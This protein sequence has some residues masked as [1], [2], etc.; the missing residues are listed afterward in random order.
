MSMKKVVALL[1]VFT[2]AAFL[3]TG[4]SSQTLGYRKYPNV[5]IDPSIYGELITLRLPLDDCEY[6]YNS[7]DCEYT[8]EGLDLIIHFT[9]RN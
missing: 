1:V 7:Y 9:K 6:I 8:E 4:C 5:R 3:L 2:L